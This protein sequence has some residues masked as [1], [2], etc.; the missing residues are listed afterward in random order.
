MQL[1]PATKQE[2]KFMAE[3]KEEGEYRWGQETVF[4]AKIKQ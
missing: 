4:T 2:E 3:K 1:L